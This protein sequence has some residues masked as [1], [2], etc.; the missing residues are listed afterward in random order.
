[1]NHLAPVLLVLGGYGLTMVCLG[2]AYARYSP[3]S[4]AVFRAGNVVPWWIAGLSQFMASHSAYLFVVVGGMI[5]GHGGFG[6]LWFTLIYPVIV[7]V[8]TLLFAR[9]WH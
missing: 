4:H 5:Y 3:S 1:M 6:L 2:V 7:V 9:R 8:G